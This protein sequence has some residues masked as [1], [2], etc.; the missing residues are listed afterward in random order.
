MPPAAIV[1]DFDGVIANSEPLH[2]RA[3]QEVL[4]PAG[5][6]LGAAE[7]YARY[8]GYDDEDMVD[9]LIADRGVVLDPARRAALLEAKGQ[10]LA[11]LL[12]Q[13]GVLFPGAVACVRELAT[14]VPLAIASGALRA[15]IELV[16]EA[17]GLRGCFHDIV[18]AGETPA[19]KPAPDP[20]LR[21]LALLQARGVVPAG[22]ARRT[23]AIEDSHFGLAAA[24]AAGLRTVALATSHPAEELAGADLV[25]SAIAEVTFDTLARLVAD[26]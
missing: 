19:G 14:R 12:Q 6:P 22:A 24:R 15:E 7:Y 8:L 2:L 20:Y 25:L 13:P 10:R 16:L 23:V 18:A 3:F 11:D 4:G 21:A 17:A 5:L 9:A 1:F 26:A